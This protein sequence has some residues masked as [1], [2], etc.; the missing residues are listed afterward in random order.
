MSEITKSDRSNPTALA[1]A[2]FDMLSPMLDSALT[3]IR[4]FAKRKPDGIVNPL[5][6]KMLNQLLV[7]V[8]GIL[9]D[10][11]SSL[12]LE[13]LDEEL[14]PQNSDVVLILGRFRAAMSQFRAK[15]TFVD[16]GTTYWSTQEGRQE[17]L[18]R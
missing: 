9:A 5:K 10:E 15:Y 16:F 6:V 7:E 3:E 8:K 13:L 1:V 11:A 14:L 2:T 4:E 17:A 18:S 12:Y